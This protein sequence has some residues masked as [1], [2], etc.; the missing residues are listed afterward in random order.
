M[1]IMFDLMG[2]V[3]GALDRSLRPGI[4]DLI[5]ELRKTGNMVYFWTNGRPEYYTK[6]LNDAGIAGEVYSKNGPL[7]FKPDICVDDTPEKWMPGMVSRVEMYVATGETA[8]PLTMVNIVP[9]EYQRI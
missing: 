8:L 6:L 4:K 7:P 9:G 1:R 2:T 3:L 5:E